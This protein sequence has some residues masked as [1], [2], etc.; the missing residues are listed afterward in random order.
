MAINKLYNGKNLS[1]IVLLAVIVLISG[2]VSVTVTQRLNENVSGNQKLVIDVQTSSDDDI[3]YVHDAIKKINCE[4]DAKEMKDS[5][6]STRIKYTSENCLVDKNYVKYEELDNYTLKYSIDSSIFKQEG[7]S[8]IQDKTIFV[9]GPGR[10]KKT[11]GIKADDYIKF[12]ISYDDIYSGYEYY[13]EYTTKCDNNS[14]CNYAEEC[15]NLKCKPLVC[16]YCQYIKNHTCVKYECC[17]NDDCPTEKFCSKNVCLNVT[18][19]SKCG[20]AKDHRWNNYTCCN[21]NMCANDESCVEHNCVRLECPFLYR[22][23]KHKCELNLTYVIILVEIILIIAILVILYAYIKR[24]RK[25]GK[26]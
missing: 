23:A 6:G 2:C 7:L 25:L 14:D 17:S 16:G 1:F 4:F 8:S 10:I 20:Y 22:I 13:A 19:Q 24:L 12:V 18:P 3:R 21:D 11:N 9:Y 15:L 5:W 26:L